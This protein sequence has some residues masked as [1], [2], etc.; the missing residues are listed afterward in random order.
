MEERKTNIKVAGK[1]FAITA[2]SEEEEQLYRQAAAVIDKTIDVRRTQFSG[3]PIE[4]LLTFVAFN[5]CKA[6]LKF[7]KEI[8]R[9][10]GELSALHGQ[11]DRYL[12]NTD[13]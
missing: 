12:D 11:L 3:K 1:V 4:D 8:E 10:N 13:K 6:R 7:Q 9:I 5:E 2:R